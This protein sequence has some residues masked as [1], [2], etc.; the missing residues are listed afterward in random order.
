MSIPDNYD[1]FLKHQ[2]DQDSKLEKMPVCSICE[3]HIQ[4]DRVYVINGDIVCPY[5]LEDEYGHN[6]EDLMEE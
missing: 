4:E 5:C 3:E 1:L 2:A 6:V